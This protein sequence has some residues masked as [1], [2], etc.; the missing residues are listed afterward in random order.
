MRAVILAGGKG[1]RLHPYTVAIPKPLVPIAETPILDIIIGQLKKSGFDHITIAVNHL[2][3]IIMAYAG[4]GS[5]WGVT[6]DYSKENKPLSTVG[7]LTLIKDLPENF[8]TINGDTLTDIDYGALLRQHTLDNRQITIA[9]KNREVKIDFGVLG[10][11]EQNQLSSFHE[12]PVHSSHV[13]MGVNCYNRTIIEALAEAEPYGFDQLMLESL[14]QGRPVQ[15]HEHD[16]FWL[17][18]GRP[19]DYQYAVEHYEEIKHLL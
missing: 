8:L 15:I 4:D 18:I 17:D 2:A 5:K 16:G 19:E 3:D 11:D 6:I 12:K 14:A 10:L 7:P 1:T 9:A 13:S